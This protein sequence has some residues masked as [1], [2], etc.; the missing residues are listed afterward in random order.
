MEGTRLRILTTL[1]RDGQATVDSL[2]H[3]LALAPATIRR[4]MDILQRDHFIAYREVKKPTGRPEYSFYLTEAGHE[5]LPKDYPHLLGALF[6]EMASLG[7]GDL[8]GRDGPKLMELVLSRMAQ[9]MADRVPVSPGD[10]LDARVATLASMLEERQMMPQVEQVDGGIRI[11][12][13]NC[14]LRSVALE[15][16]IVC[17]FHSHL[18]SS[19]LGTPVSLERCIAWGDTSCSHLVYYEA[20][21]LQGVPAAY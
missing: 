19:V 13:L 21:A 5:V 15:H 10:D 14:P 18:I 3:S 12:V 9:R 16:G 8:Q 4:H 2:A 17:T 6:Q 1:Q 11:M 7:Q 20:V